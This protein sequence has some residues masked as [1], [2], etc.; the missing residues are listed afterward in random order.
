MNLETFTHCKR[1]DRREA[2]LLSLV[3]I[4]REGSFQLGAGVGNI[5]GLFHC[6]VSPVWNFNNPLHAGYCQ[7][8]F[9]VFK[10][11]L[12]LFLEWNI[13]QFNNYCNMNGWHHNSEKPNRD[14]SVFFTNLTRS[15]RSFVIHCQSF[16]ETFTQLP[17]WRR[18]TAQSICGKDYSKSDPGDLRVPALI[19]TYCN[20]NWPTN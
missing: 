15:S 12:S 17:D 1:F 16:H 13:K 20:T 14:V 18:L 7:E 19:P 6:N 2:I 4:S 11:N 10:M 8:W 5:K 3:I 9:V